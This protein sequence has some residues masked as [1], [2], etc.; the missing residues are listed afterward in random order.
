MPSIKHADGWGI[1]YAACTFFWS[2]FAKVAL[3]V[4]RKVPSGL[5]SVHGSDPRGW[6]RT[7]LFC[8]LLQSVLTIICAKK[9]FLGFKNNFLV[10]RSF[11][12]YLLVEVSRGLE[13]GFLHGVV[14]FYIWRIT[15]ETLSSESFV[16]FFTN[17]YLSLVADHPVLQKGRLFRSLARQDLEVRG[18]RD[19]AKYLEVMKLC[20]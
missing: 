18:L 6:V 15:F 8:K 5:A 10:V 20:S 4:L 1:T 11:K 17:K 19:L 13:R 12:L 9:S 14:E 7:S 2:S 16:N 3:L